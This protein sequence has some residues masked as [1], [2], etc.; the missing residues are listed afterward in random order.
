MAFSGREL[1]ICLCLCPIRWQDIAGLLHFGMCLGWQKV[2]KDHLKNTSSPLS[3]EGREEWPELAVPGKL[4]FQ[5]L[6]RQCPA[7]VYLSTTSG[8]DVLWMGSEGKELKQAHLPAFERC[9]NYRATGHP[10][11]RAL[12]RDRHVAWK[13]RCQRQ[14]RVRNNISGWSPPCSHLQIGVRMKNSTSSGHSSP[15]RVV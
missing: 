10:E 5:G 9:S 15:A 13:W 7:S 12:L 8:S 3:V 1:V 4:A 2:G 11:N 6:D 14:G